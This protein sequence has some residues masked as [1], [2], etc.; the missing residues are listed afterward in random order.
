[1]ASIFFVFTIYLTVSAGEPKQAELN[2]IT[3]YYFLIV[4][5][6]WQIIKK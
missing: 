1:M 6:V 4:G 5:T 2:L 3:A